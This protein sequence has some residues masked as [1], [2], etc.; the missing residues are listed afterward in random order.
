LKK[1]I[2]ALIEFLRL[3]YN[4]RFGLIIHN[5]FLPFLGKNAQRSRFSRMTFGVFD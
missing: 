4:W 1:D 3:P 2:D 5:L